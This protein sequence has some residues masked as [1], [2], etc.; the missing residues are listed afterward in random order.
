MSRNAYPFFFVLLL[1]AN[2]CGARRGL[3]DYSQEIAKKVKVFMDAGGFFTSI[4]HD[5]FDPKEDVVHAVAYRTLLPA[6]ELLGR[7]DVRR[8]AFEQCLGGLDRFKMRGERSLSKTA[9]GRD[10]IELETVEQGPSSPH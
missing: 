8:F 10:R 4:N 7:A 2:G 9:R 3:A 6:A 1:D 5:T